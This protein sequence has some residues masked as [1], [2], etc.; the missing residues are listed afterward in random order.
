MLR[1]EDQAVWTEDI[2]HSRV[3]ADTQTCRHR[4]YME[5]VQPVGYREKLLFELHLVIQL[6]SGRKVN[7][8]E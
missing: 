4:T 5:A 6:G 1:L 3:Y 7:G 8:D 2:T